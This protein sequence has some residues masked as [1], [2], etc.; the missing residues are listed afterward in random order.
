MTSNRIK[1]IAC[2][3]MLADHAGILLF[4]EVEILRWIGRLAMPLFAFFIA[5]G[6][7]HTSRP[8][9]YFLRMFL[10]GLPCPIVYFS[11]QILQGN[12]VDIYLN[13]LFTFSVSILLCRLYLLCEKMLK[14][15]DKT[16]FLLLLF[17]F[18]STI[19]LVIF[20]DIFCLVSERLVGIPIYLDYGVAGVL[21]PLFALP[22]K[23]HGKR[24]GIYTV[25]VI[26]FVLSLT[27]RMPYA[28]CALFALPILYFYNG[29]RGKYAGKYAFYLFYPLH[30]AVLYGIDWLFF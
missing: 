16:R 14:N 5:E 19:A 25:G 27:S 12:V 21:L 18:A 23:T 3:S 2:I 7:Y 15:R 1:C 10:L 17:F 20:F 13:I 28:W 8:H 11:E 9:R 6:S 29:K 24:M 4:P 22:Q 30:L 26:L